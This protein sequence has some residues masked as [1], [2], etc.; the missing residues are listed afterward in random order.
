MSI[1]LFIKYQIKTKI[2]DEHIGY[3]IDIV[4]LLVKII[5]TSNIM[6]T[7]KTNNIKP[8]DCMKKE[9]KQFTVLYSLL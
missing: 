8:S 6:E 4:I 1:C 7:N 9:F 5:I 2:T 3:E